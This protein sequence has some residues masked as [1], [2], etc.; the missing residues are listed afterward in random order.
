MKHNFFKYSIGALSLII[1]G[2]INTPAFCQY[3]FSNCPYGASSAMLPSGNE[4]YDAIDFS[5]VYLDLSSEFYL[6]SNGL[7]NQFISDFY[8]GKFLNEPLKTKNL[9]RLNTQNNLF[10]YIFNTGL[11]VNI[12]AKRNGISYYAAYE[13]H[14]FMELQFHKNFFNIVFFGN[15]DFADQ[16]ASL[17]KQSMKILNYQQIKAGIVKTWFKKNSVS[18]FSAGIGINNGQNILEYNIPKATFFTQKEA[19]YFSLDMNMSMKRSDTLNSKFGAENGSGLSV[20]LSYYHRDSR[21]SF[22]IKVEDLGYIRWNKNSQQY[23]KDT[24]VYFDGI[25]IKNILD[26]NSQTIKGMSGDSILNAFAFA[27]KT[28][29]FTE[30]IPMKAS[31]NYTRYFFHD[32]LSLSLSLIE[33]HFLHFKPLIRFVP[34]YNIPVKRSKICIAPSFE[35]GGYGK[36]NCGLGVSASVYRKFYIELNTGFINAYAGS[37]NAAGLGAMVSIIKTL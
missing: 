8:N 37:Q 17:D 9:N 20:D 32:K 31:I 25:E 28:K 33:Y 34:S 4:S 19:E 29:A 10:G 23:T 13:N 18:V 16:Y 26:I 24:L 1:A 30:M 27:N 36:F 6:N 14:N 5:K 35:Y 12:P 21:S 15:K 11:S 2:F 22:E 3:K 7:T